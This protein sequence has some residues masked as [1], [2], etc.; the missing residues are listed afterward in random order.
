MKTVKIYVLGLLTLGQIQ[1]Q[2]RETLVNETFVSTFSLYDR[3]LEE[4]LECEPGYRGGFATA[5]VLF[6][7]SHTL[8]FALPLYS[9]KL[10]AHSSVGLENDPHR[11]PPGALR[12]YEEGCQ[13]SIDRIKAA[14]KD[15]EIV[16][17]KVHR[18]VNKYRNTGG[19]SYRKLNG[20][21]VSEKY[22]TF[23]QINEFLRVEF[24]G[25]QFSLTRSMNVKIHTH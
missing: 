17:V 16:E 22:Q 3:P 4:V 11:L 20:E 18:V 10:I 24:A 9:E 12:P 5:D 23:D 8:D 13:L 15:K 6:L 21:I 2:N 7:K 14:I 1:A 25:E 19:R